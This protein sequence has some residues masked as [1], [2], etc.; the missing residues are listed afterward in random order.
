MATW[1]DLIKAIPG[2][3][4]AIANLVGDVSQ[5]GSSAAKLASTRIDEARRRIVDRTNESSAV[6]AALADSKVAM[7]RA[8]RD[9]SVEYIEANAAAIG[10]RAFDHG[11]E[12]LIR[13][14]R[15]REAVV[16]R[17]IEDL[18]ATPPREIPT[19]TPSEDWLNLFGRYAENASSTKMR[20]HWAQ[21]LSGEIRKPGSF[22]FATL[23]LASI[24]DERLANSIEAVRP[25]ILGD[26]HIPLIGQFRR[27][28]GYATML[29]L[30]GIGFLHLGDHAVYVDAQPNAGH[31]RFETRGGTVIVP[32]PKNRLFVSGEPIVLD[33]D[34][35][36]PSAFISRSGLELLSALPDVAQAAELAEAIK[37]YF[38]EAGWKGVTL[39]KP[40]DQTPENSPERGAD[41]P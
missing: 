36:I 39:E 17:T 25:W 28:D 19:E 22:S 13:E 18:S 8:V 11:I 7:I 14:Q 38:E 32:N 6:S 31:V 21:I 2:L 4:T 16:L 41:G 24:L 15:N 40:D 35:S 37:T 10:E 5:V 34:P 33:H 12:R 23:L 9:A 29:E 20:E 27:G 3:G 26:Q 1:L 30:A